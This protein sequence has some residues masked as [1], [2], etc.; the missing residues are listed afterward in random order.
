MGPTSGEGGAGT[1]GGEPVRI[2]KYLSRAGVASRR[3]SEELML[4]GR[5]RVNGEVVTTLGSKVTPGRDRVE[6]DGARVRLPEARWIVLHKPAGT[7]TTADD[8]RGRTTV[9]DLLPPE[10]REL[11][12]TYVGRLDLETEGL[13]LLTNEGDLVH[14][15][16][17]PSGEVDREYRVGVRGEVA[18]SVPAR[19]RSGVELE[20]GPARA[21]GAAVVGA[22]RDGSVLELVLRE[23]RN[24]EV[25]RMCDAVGH[26]VRWLRRVRFG[27]IGLGDLPPGRWRDLTPDE[28]DAVRKRA[29]EAAN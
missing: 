8:P 26:P 7:V 25:R 13:L 24:R 27:P 6:V 20:D 2:Q 10:L 11:G 29:E 5:V 14:A 1:L 28:L 21:A 23:G 9:Y 3:A 15:L 12:L 16:L 4:Q 17:H 22:E 19:L 18:G